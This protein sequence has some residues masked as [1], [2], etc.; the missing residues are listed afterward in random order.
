MLVEFG[1]KEEPPDPTVD[2]ENIEAT[3]VDAM[4]ET[5]AITS[6][7]V[8]CDLTTWKDPNKN[9]K[10]QETGGLFFLIHTK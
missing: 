8:D 5:D 6:D 4:S 9:C 3:V 7:V 2:D 1:I 10:I